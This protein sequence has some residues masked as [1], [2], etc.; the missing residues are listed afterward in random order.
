MTDT[1]P[2]A[3]TGPRAAETARPW[4]HALLAA[5]VGVG[6]AHF[7][8]VAAFLVF[9]TGVGGLVALLV[10]TAAT[11]VALAAVAVVGTRRAAGAW[12]G[13]SAVVLVPAVLLADFGPGLLGGGGGAGAFDPSPGLLPYAV[14]AVLAA[15]PALLLHAG[16]ARL[17]GLTVSGAGVVAIVVVATVVGVSAHNGVVQRDQQAIA[18]AQVEIGADFR[19]VTIAPSGYGSIFEANIEKRLPGF[20][21]VF[22][23]PASKGHAPGQTS[24]D[25]LTV[26]T[27]AADT[28]VCGR[29][30]EGVGVDGGSES[31]TSCTVGDRFTHRVSPHGHEVSAVVGDT[32]VAV[33]ARTEVDVAVLREAVRSAEPIGDAAYRHVL[34]GDGDEYTDELDGNRCPITG[35]VCG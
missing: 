10:V 11:G 19:P 16:R 12:L 17:V 9:F 32:L 26:V 6:A 28:A 13:L 4:L 7:A 23:S 34:L 2:S 8:H 27:V 20:L 18:R 33:S 1:D 15:A 35:V 31:E 25:D 21:Q 24:G 5:V 14:G 22:S 3:A 30:V 29:P